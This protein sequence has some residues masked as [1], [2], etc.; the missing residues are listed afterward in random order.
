[1]GAER[2]KQYLPLGG[3]PLLWHTL[4]AFERSRWVDRLILVLRP[5]DMDLCRR[6]VLEPGHF[7][8]VQ[9]VVEGGAERHASVLAGLGETA[10]ADEIIL[11][12]DAVRPFFD[13]G[14]LRRVVEAAAECGA[15]VPG[16]PLKET[17]KR[18]VDGQVEATVDRKALF[19]AQTPQGF[20]REVLR[21]AYGRVAQTARITDDAMLVEES[22][23]PVR[24]V[25]GA[26]QNIKITTPEDLAWAAWHLE[27][28][29]R[30]RGD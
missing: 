7:G 5:E 14:L 24:L 26:E 19:G 22:G 17:V 2:P 25:E 23:H 13:D 20:R 4:E 21:Q 15:A 18:A 3:R 27:R 1:M 16:L 6:E 10:A 9:G 30:E 28:G 29:R 11:V 12:H 8:K